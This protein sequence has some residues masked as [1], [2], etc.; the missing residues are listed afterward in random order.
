MDFVKEGF[1]GLGHAQVME[2]I[3]CPKIQQF[4]FPTI[5]N[6]ILLFPISGPLELGSMNPSSL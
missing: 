4:F 5:I 3:A 6:V 1:K 2:C